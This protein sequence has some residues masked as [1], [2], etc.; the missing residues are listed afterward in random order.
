MHDV[1]PAMTTGGASTAPGSR[2]GV[3]GLVHDGG[4]CLIRRQRPA[5]SDREP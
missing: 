3:R 1:G 2:A 5:R 4:V